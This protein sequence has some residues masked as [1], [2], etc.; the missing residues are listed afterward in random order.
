[1]LS[2]QHGLAVTASTAESAARLDATITAYCGF[3]LDTGDRLRATLAG[4][5]HVV[6]G[7]ILYGYFMLLLVK[8]ELVAR[9]REAADAAAASMRAV[10]S[11]PREA[12]HLRALEAWIR[13]DL[14]AATVILETILVAYPHD[15]V[16]LKLVQYLLFYAGDWTRMHGTVSGAV[17][18]WDDTVP[19][20]GFALGCHAFGLEE[21]GEYD[22]AERVGKRAIE[23]EPADI[24]G[25]H[26][27]AHVFE[28]QDRAQD[29]LRWIDGLAPQWR[30]ANNFAF[31]VWW[32]RCLFLLAEGRFDEALARY[33]GEVRADSTDEHLDIVNA[34]SLLWRFEQAGVPVGARWDELA[35]RAAAR[36]DDHMLVFSDTHFAMALAAAGTPEDF[37]RWCQSST[38]FA[39]AAKESQAAVMSAAGLVLA[40]AAQAHRSGAFACAVDLLLPVRA[41]IHRIGGSHAQRDLFEQLLIDAAV[42]AERWDTARELLQ[43][44]LAARPGNVWGR[45]ELRRIETR[46]LHPPAQGRRGVT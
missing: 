41:A 16:A 35:A 6:F 12:M 13:R 25:A 28:M 20:Y 5:P 34:V 22:A 11:T 37:T 43:E 32:H 10:G 33:D 39:T 4:D 15:I 38:R 30:D 18:A 3:K 23:R 17:A 24:W 21:C 45:T 40:E 7:H 29:G 26:A 14:D 8:R 1:M 27:V 31:H 9:A 42:K 2:D 46:R 19:G 44:R 36:L